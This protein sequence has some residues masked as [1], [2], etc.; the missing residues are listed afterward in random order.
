MV[1]SIVRRDITDCGQR[2]RSMQSGSE[3]DSPGNASTTTRPRTIAEVIHVMEQW[4]LVGT[5]ERFADKTREESERD[6]DLELR[7]YKAGKADGLNL[8]SDLL[9]ATC[10]IRHAHRGH[11]SPGK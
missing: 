6:Q 9:R 3:S 5:L 2:K 1:K 7:A 4:K 11:L 10:R 8:A